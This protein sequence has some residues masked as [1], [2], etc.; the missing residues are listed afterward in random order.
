MLTIVEPGWDWA[1]EPESSDSILTH[2]ELCGRTCYKSEDL[3]TKESAEKFVRKICHNKH[4]SVLEHK[5]LSVRIVCSRACSHQ[6]VRHRL[7]A[8]SQESQRY[9][10][11]GKK[12]FQVIAPESLDMTYGEYTLDGG[13][14]YDSSSRIFDHHQLFWLNNVNRAFLAYQYALETMPP[15]D[16]RFLLPNACKTE[17]VMTCNLRMWRHIFRERA[18]NPRAQWEIRKIFRDMM[19]HF[20]ILLPAVFGDLV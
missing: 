17:I 10:N 3:I 20:K 9:C 12:G 2:L 8:Y 1:F 16:A 15:E 18:L 6:I 13:W 4:E 7:A 11:Y 14:I 5:T 19:D